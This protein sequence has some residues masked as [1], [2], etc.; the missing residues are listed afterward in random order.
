MTTPRPWETPELHSAFQRLWDDRKPGQPFAAADLLEALGPVHAK[1]CDVLRWFAVWLEENIVA[2]WSEV[3]S[4][5][6]RA[7][8]LCPGDA[9][10]L[11][12]W[13]VA[14]TNYA[15]MVSQ[16]SRRAVLL[17]AQRVAREGL[18]HAPECADLH[19]TLGLAAY[20]DDSLPVEDAEHEFRLALQYRPGHTAARLYLAHCLQ[21]V[22]QWHDALRMLREMDEAAV[23]DAFG[24]AQQWRVLKIKEQIA[25][26]LF[27]LGRDSDATDATERFVE[28]AERSGP[29]ELEPVDAL[30]SFASRLPEP[31]AERLRALAFGK[32]LV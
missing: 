29:G 23:V 12:S 11:Q 28:A 32:P 15:D 18:E 10:V 24:T 22:G 8:D 2:E 19:Y 3:E 9:S 7:A 26:C 16:E 6:R 5:Y 25:T 30:L 27:R 14:A 1:D 21:D 31:L 4:M 17:E 20:M 13:A